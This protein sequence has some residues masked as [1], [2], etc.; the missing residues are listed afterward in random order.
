MEYKIRLTR[1]LSIKSEKLPAMA[2][3]F[4]ATVILRNMSHI[5]TYKTYMGNQQQ[6]IITINNMSNQLVHI[7]G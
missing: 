4:P 2:H 7:Y 5:F 1:S 6:L 3:V